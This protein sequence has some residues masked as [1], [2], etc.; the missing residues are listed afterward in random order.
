MFHQILE[1]VFLC[2]GVV[3]L[4]AGRTVALLADRLG[5]TVSQGLK[6]C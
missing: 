5:C 4:V 6:R 3:G 1:L 2:K